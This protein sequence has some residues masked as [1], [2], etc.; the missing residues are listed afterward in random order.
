MYPAHRSVFRSPVWQQHRQQSL[1]RTHNPGDKLNTQYNLT[2]L[3]SPEQGAVS[4]Q[5]YPLVGLI[6]FT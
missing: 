6:C 1:R 5:A 4:L 2:A 3:C